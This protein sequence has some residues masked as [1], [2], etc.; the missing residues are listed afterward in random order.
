MDGQIAQ[1]GLRWKNQQAL[2]YKTGHGAIEAGVNGLEE[3]GSARA[4]HARR[5]YI[6]IV[7]DDAFSLRKHTHTHTHIYK[8]M[9][10]YYNELSPR[11]KAR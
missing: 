1:H 8:Q 7:D 2:L 9:G 3:S 4:S 10:Y 6:A 11:R 5:A